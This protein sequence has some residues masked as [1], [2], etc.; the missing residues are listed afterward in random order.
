MQGL[1]QIIEFYP[2]LGISIIVSVLI[3]Y[4]MTLLALRKLRSEHSIQIKRLET[5]VSVL[6]SGAL[7]M[8]Q[9]ML[10][11]EVKY[12]RLNQALDEIRQS[13]IEFSYTQAQKLISQGV[14]D[15]AVAANSGLSSTEINLMRLLQNQDYTAHSF[16]HV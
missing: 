12:Q 2:V 13:D 6:T 14:D 11:L 8:G 5:N 3:A 16:D 15:N 9:K 10:S 7:G 4:V 1:D